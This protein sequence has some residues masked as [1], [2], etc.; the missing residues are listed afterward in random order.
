MGAA[1]SVSTE[2]LLSDGDL[3]KLVLSEA[4]LPADLSDLSGA[5]LEEL[6]AHVS[7]YRQLAKM[8]VEKATTFD[9][10]DAATAASS[11]AAA[12]SRNV[13]QTREEN[14]QEEFIAR[15]E[16][17]KNFIRACGNG[18]LDE[19]K[20]LHAAG[21]KIEV[22]SLSG[23]TAAF[24]AAQGGHL[25]VLKWLDSIGADFS[26]RDYG[27]STPFLE[28]GRAGRLGS[29]EFLAGLPP[30]KG[31]DMHAT[32]TQGWN[33]LTCAACAGYVECV[34]VLYHKGLSAELVDVD[35]K[36]ALDWA[37]AAQRS[38]VVEF[39]TQALAAAPDS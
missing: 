37:E 15:P 25:D 2:A 1:S 26:A 10:A 23:G 30:E 21:V 31:A 13:S 6:R 22:Q 16:D 29:I 3:K 34:K 18:N 32:D 24:F 38:E 36:T 27:G 7:K 14:V 9:A 11:S 33:A 17:E 5:D 8:F 20:R 28:A 4:E 39:L 35:G 19:A 12:Q